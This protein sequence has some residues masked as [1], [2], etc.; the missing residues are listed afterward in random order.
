MKDEQGNILDKDTGKMT[1][2]STVEV[3]MGQLPWMF[4]CRWWS[5]LTVR[6]PFMN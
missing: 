6:S 3:T 5:A 4:S 2:G 1:M